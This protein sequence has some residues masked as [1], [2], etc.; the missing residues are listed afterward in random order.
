LEYPD[1]TPT[2]PAIERY[3]TKLYP[4]MGYKEP[5]SLYGTI[6]YQALHTIVLAM[7]KA[8]TTTDA[9]KIRAA[10]PLVVPIDKKY[11]TTGFR[12]WKE[13]GEGV[14]D[15]RLGRYRNG[16]LVEVALPKK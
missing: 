11:D 6:V 15:Q 1:V 3:K 10:A 8:G 9:W 2:P 12:A 16:K 4:A 14:M 7:Q 13:N 5:F